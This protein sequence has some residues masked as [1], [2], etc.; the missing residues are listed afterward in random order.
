MNT[1]PFAI[2]YQ[3]M[4]LCGYADPVKTIE[5]TITSSMIIYIKEWCIGTLYCKEEKWSMDQPI[6]PEFVADLG[7]YIHSHIKSITKAMRRKN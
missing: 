5:N 4:L 1:I 2:V 6:D 3:G 7:N